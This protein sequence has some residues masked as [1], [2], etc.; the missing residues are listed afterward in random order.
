M[1][2]SFSLIAV[3]LT[4]V[5]VVHA[6]NNNYQEAWKALSENNAS[7]AR[8]LFEKETSNP[9][10]E[11]D[12]NLSLILLDSYNGQEIKSLERFRQVMTKAQDPYPYLYAFWFNAVAF[13]GYG[14]KEKAELDFINQCLKDPKA[15][16]SIQSAFHYVKGLH[17]L[18]SNNMA[19]AKKEWE[20]MASITQWQY[21]GPFDNIKGSGFDKNYEPI[22]HPQKPNKFV[23]DNF[24][25][26]DWFKPE[27]E[28]IDGWVFTLSHIRSY[29]A[30]LY[31]QTFVY[32][33]ED[34]D[35]VL[36]AG[37]NG[38][39]KVWMNDKLIIKESEDR[40]T[41]LDVYKS[42]CKLKK[43]FN[44]VLV[45]MGYENSN[46]PNFIVRLTDEKFS[47]IKGLKVEADYQPYTV[48]KGEFDA[49]QNIPHF[50]EKYF[51]DKIKSEPENIVNHLLYTQV[52]LRHKKIVEGRKVMNALSTKYPKNVLIK[53]YLLQCL[54]KSETR[55][56]LLK[57]LDA[58][59]ELDSKSYLSIVL[60]ITQLM[61]EEKYD[62]ALE[63]LNEQIQLYGE[64]E[65]AISKK[66]DIL[67][68]Q[69]NY[70]ELKDLIDETY[71][72]YPENP[73]FVDMK[74]SLTN[75]GRNDPKEAVKI[76]EKY[77]KNNFEA[78]LVRQLTGTYFDLGYYEKGLATYQ[79]I[80]DIAPYD[81]ES[82]DDMANIYFSAQNYSLAL[83][84]A[85]KAYNMAPYYSSYLYSMG[86]IHEAT[87]QKEKA[88][89]FYEKALY[90]NPTNFDVR[91]KITQLEKSPSAQSLIPEY[92]IYD[93]IKKSNPQDK[94][95]KHDWYYIMDE[96]IRIVYPEGASEEYYTY[97]V[98]ILEEKGIDY[99]KEMPI[100]YN[101]YSQRIVIEKAEVVKS[102]G[103]KIAAEKTESD[104]IFTN[105]EKGDVVYVRYK[106][107]NY[108]WGRF[109]KDFWDKYLF[110]AFVPSDMSRYR[111]LIA[112]DIKFDYKFIQGDLKPTIQTKG[113]Y[114]LY[115]WEKAQASAVE[116]EY[117]MPS[118]VDVAPALHISTLKRWQDIVDW[119]GDVSAKQAEAGFEIK[120]ICKE[121]FT[122]DKT[123][124]QYEKAKIIYD[125]IIK[126][127][128]YSSVS[129]RQSAYV[130]QKAVKVLNTKLGDCKDLSTLYASMAREVGL[131]VNLVLLSSK[132]N[133]RN[134]MLLP[135]LEF[136]H[137]IVKVK[138]DN[139]PFYVELTDADLP[140][141][142]IPSYDITSQ[143]LEIPFKEQKIES[144]IETLQSVNST[145]HRITRKCTVKIGEQDL[146]VETK[147]IRQG[148]ATTNTRYNYKNLNEKQRK[149][150]IQQAI[151]RDFKNPVIL[152]E[153]V[154][155]DLVSLTDTLT[156]Q[157]KY[158]VKNEILDIGS[159][160]TFRVPFTDNIVRLDR[161]PEEKRDF[162]IE[163]WKYDDTE[164]YIADMV[165]QLPQGYEY[166]DVPQN[167]S[168]KF[169]NLDYQISYKKINNQTLEVKRDVKWLQEM[170]EPNY[171]EEF[172]E[173]LNKIIAQE[174]KYIT[175]KGLN[176]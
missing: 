135:S 173:F 19:E 172:K 102:N 14:K 94:I 139:K 47:P 46:I 93:L 26:I 11:I 107:E 89:E 66:M 140:F 171:Y 113:K 72:K 30:I 44:R 162:P 170:V 82:Y 151:A 67:A 2:K 149:E 117:Y 143:I 15:N 36:C 78:S 127:I 34:M 158:T 4:I 121:L 126:N 155:N 43:G 101:P 98:K 38:T 56:E 95:G 128:H 123:F 40:Q 6:Q 106:L 132:D 133:G 50:A 148:Y 169:G 112:N 21:V 74:F 54:L 134:N 129:F 138:I 124:S 45:Q 84:Y 13:G 105:L 166:V 111:L 31:A 176:K 61:E 141:G 146:S 175:F 163:L 161:F 8:E 125:Y 3:F 51:E 81:S 174:N 32:A 22:S 92:D 55:T 60:K 16:G 115:T 12:A 75:K 64:S 79:K 160:K 167:F 85:E 42:R 9:A 83:K 33:P 77:L 99:W 59:K 53:F 24:T 147:T 52:L 23:S 49:S 39:L 41:E 76:A 130:P 80:I 86:K 110:V 69:K 88:L 10:S 104:V 7:K 154:F 152:H 71:Q 116:S 63:K 18:K 29:T 108:Y 103:S 119:Y 118:L 37:V 58:L 165:I 150:D 157:Y 1:K 114:T 27:A 159:L 57:E 145:P 87:R 25:N 100:S 68:N 35:I 144:H 73:T 153:L 122:Q 91:N 28:H 137:C 156:Y 62:E 48:D 17:F 131:D 142:S 120:E 97:C 90:Y 109:A 164:N 70:Q 20:Q 96:K 168:I 65:E 136:N 5:Q